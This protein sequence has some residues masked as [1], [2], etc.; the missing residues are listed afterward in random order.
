[1]TEIQVIDAIL[2]A[3]IVLM[4]LVTIVRTVGPP[5][6]PQFLLVTFLLGAIFIIGLD[7]YQRMALD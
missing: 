4:I 5:P 2:I 3:L 6:I 1:M 7:L